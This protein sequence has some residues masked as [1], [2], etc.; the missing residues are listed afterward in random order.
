MPLGE[1]PDYSPDTLLRYGTPKRL[2]YSISAPANTNTLLGTIGGKGII[3]GG[4]IDCIKTVTGKDDKPGIVIDGVPWQHYTFQDY[5]EFNLDHPY[6][7]PLF[8]TKYDNNNFLYIV[9]IAGFITF[10]SLVQVKYKETYGDTPPVSGGV[11][12][13]LIE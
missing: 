6:C 13:A 2:G 8:L 9:S 1:G 4:Y 10:E 5:E 12:Y 11:T 3:Y 7:Y